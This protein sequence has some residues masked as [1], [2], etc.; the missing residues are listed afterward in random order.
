MN[1]KIEFGAGGNRPDGWTC[2][3]AEV[4]IT[5]PLPY[6]DNTVD[7]IRAEHVCEHI[8]GPEFL[9]FLDECYRILKP[10]GRL[11]LCMPVMTNL[12]LVECRDIIT[13]HGHLCAYNPQLINT[14]VHVAGFR[15]GQEFA[16]R[17]DTDGHWRVIGKE[18]DDKE[19]YRCEA[20][21]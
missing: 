12:S 6:E 9:R 1:K 19:T 2:H 14:F 17:N 21:K 10:G 8:T 20:I 18:K 15:K 16:P 3:D 4:D 11:R 7:K 13:N 5:K